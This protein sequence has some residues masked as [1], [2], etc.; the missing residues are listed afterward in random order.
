MD[1]RMLLEEAVVDD[2]TP[3]ATEVG[4]QEQ[5][6]G[7]AEAPA[8]AWTSQT[9]TL[10]NSLALNLSNNGPLD[11][12][13]RLLRRIKQELDTMSEELAR[14]EEKHDSDIKKLKTTHLKEIR[15]LSESVRKLENEKSALVAENEGL[16]ERVRDLEGDVEHLRTELKKQA[17]AHNASMEA[18]REELTADI[19]SKVEIA[20]KNLALQ[21]QRQQPIIMDAQDA[22]DRL[23]AGQIAFDFINLA[24]EFVFGKE[25]AGNLHDITCLDDISDYME[26]STYR[27]LASRYRELSAVIKNRPACNR[28]VRKLK[29]NRRQPAHPP[30]TRALSMEHLSEVLQEYLPTDTLQ[31]FLADYAEVRKLNHRR[32]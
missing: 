21:K 7:A 25:S 20:F 5:G 6:P 32:T 4:R 16:M 26:I 29:E 2:A 12:A 1:N 14:T 13:T 17:R 24:A 9:L 22:A 19:D 30:H 27:H 31:G 8:T 18:L 23:E 3:T 10:V 15:R 11:E 28:A